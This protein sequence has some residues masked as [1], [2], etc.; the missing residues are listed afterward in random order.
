MILKPYSP[1]QLMLRVE[2]GL[3]WKPRGLLSADGVPMTKA[4]TSSGK[5]SGTASDKPEEP[6]R[7]TILVVEDTPDNLL[8]LSGLLKVDSTQ[9]AVNLPRVTEA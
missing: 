4:A 3:V 5:T 1:S 8:L 7:P 6:Q 2:K 9:I